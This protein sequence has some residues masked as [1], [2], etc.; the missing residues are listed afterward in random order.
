MPKKKSSRGFTPTTKHID[1]SYVPPTSLLTV[2]SGKCPVELMGTDDESIKQ[3]VEELKQTARGGYEHSVNSIQYWVRD[4]YNPTDP[5][6]KAVRKRIYDLR[7][8]L[9]LKWCKL[10]T[11]SKEAAERYEREKNAWKGMGPS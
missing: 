1:R 6:W 7:G 2:P 3:W 11:L 10:P 4:F 8:E 9:G 5:E